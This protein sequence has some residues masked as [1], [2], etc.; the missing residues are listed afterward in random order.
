MVIGLAFVR[1]KWTRL[2]KPGDR[3]T[4]KAELNKSEIS[5]MLAAISHEIQ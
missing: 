2:A 5:S 1:C 4:A 3:Y